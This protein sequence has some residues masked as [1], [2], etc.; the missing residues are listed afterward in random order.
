M[1]TRALAAEIR[2]DHKRFVS[3]LEKASGI[4]FGDFSGVLCE[5]QYII[6]KEGSKEKV[7][8]DVQLNFEKQTVGIE[9]KLDH[10]LTRDQIEDQKEALGENAT[11]FV[12][13]PKKDLAPRWLDEF[14]SV[15]II[16][17]ED[18]LDS[19]DDSR[20]TMD[21]IQGEGRLLKTTVESWLSNLRLEE[22]LPGWAVQVRRGNSGM[23]SV[24]IESLTAL[25]DGQFIRGQLEVAGRGM[26]G[27]LKAVRFNTNI[28]ISVDENDENYYDPSESNV[29]PDWIGH[30]QTLQRE[31]LDGEEDRLRISMSRPGTS[32]RDHGKWKL[33][34][35]EKHL[36]KD[37]LYLAKGYTDGWALGPKTKSVPRED[38]EE[39]ASITVEIFTRWQEA[40]TA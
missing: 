32:K 7:R 33:P 28:G 12:L 20:L 29:A 18:A 3:F 4:D 26:P 30:L 34:L 13:L 15:V 21:D 25:K 8:I 2:H 27:S 5:V 1:A 36:H 14:P 11:I 17:W 6:T 22:R 40:E 16:G 10:E 9:A 24:V 39:L 23:P 35:A 19:F 38:L 37:H 31:V